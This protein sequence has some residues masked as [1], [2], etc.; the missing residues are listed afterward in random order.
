MRDDIT[1]YTQA[2]TAREI[3]IPRHLIELTVGAAV[4]RWSTRE[5][6]TWSGETWIGVGAQVEDLRTLVGGAMSGRISLPNHDNAMSALVLADGVAGRRVRIWQ[7]Y[8]MGP[9]T[10]EDAVLVFSGEADGAPDVGETRVS[11]E[12]VTEGRALQKAPRLYWDMLF[13]H[14]PPAGTVISIG[15]E[16]FTLER[17]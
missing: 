7:L 2:E 12:I 15:G 4:Y 17:G 3:T 10:A 1:P 16:H 11:I 6:V 14:I 13:N 8:G 5:D 9:F